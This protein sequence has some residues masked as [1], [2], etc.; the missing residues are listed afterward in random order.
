LHEKIIFSPDL[1]E[2]LSSAKEE[3][4]KLVGKDEYSHHGTF[5]RDD[6]VFAFSHGG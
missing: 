6:D 1:R 4:Q 2:L 5:G 3:H